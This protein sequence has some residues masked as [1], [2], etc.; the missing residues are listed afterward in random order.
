MNV[1]LFGFTFGKYHDTCQHC[2]LCVIPEHLIV[3]HSLSDWMKYLLLDSF[4]V[5]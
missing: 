3:F 2:Q 1:I 5:N 4:G